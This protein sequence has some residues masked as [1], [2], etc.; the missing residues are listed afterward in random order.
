[1]T[2][3]ERMSGVVDLCIGSNVPP[4]IPAPPCSEDAIVDAFANAEQDRCR[5]VPSSGH[6]MVWTGTH[7]RHDETGL[8]IERIRR[9]CRAVADPLE[10][11]TL[12]RRIASMRTINAV[13][14]LA[15]TDLRFATPSDSWDRG[16][17][18]LN[19][20]A[21]VVDLRTGELGIHSPDDLISRMTTASPR[22]MCPGWRRFLSEVTDGNQALI[23][24]LQRVA[25]YCLTGSMKAHVFFFLHGPGANGKSVFLT[26]LS[27]V[28]GGYAMTA[29]LD[30]F[31]RNRGTRH[32]TDLAGLAKARLVTVTETEP[33]RQ[34]SESRIKAIT[35]GDTLRVRHLYRDFFEVRPTFKIVMAGNARPRIDGVGE[36]M[37]RR[38]HLIPFDVTIPDNRRDPDLIDRLLTE[39]D[40]ILV[41]MIEGCLE[42]Q[43]RGLNP[44]PEVTEAAAAYLAE[45]DLVGQWIGERC[46]VSA[47]ASAAGADLYGDWSKWADI[48]GHEAGTGRA[49]GEAL[50]ARGF[51][52][53]RTAASRGWSG[54]A[55]CQTADDRSAS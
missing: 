53:I 3:S 36:A 1:M 15:R 8:I 4:E 24:Y 42:W 28:L 29:P 11:K 31:V 20:P 10:D 2:G 12:K 7:W 30:T 6:W 9:V 19:T 35:G 37:R 54:I 50:G 18:V 55:L 40:G 52:R 47:N 27:E 32:P 33:G 43:A 44:P 14:R 38:L 16:D 39:R 25:G 34:W 46:I 5:F 51:S 48:H 41:W 13:E 21:G 26:V 49:F 45:E 17:M 23:A 22:G